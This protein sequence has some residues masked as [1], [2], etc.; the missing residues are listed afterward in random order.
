LLENSIR[1]VL[2]HAWQQARRPRKRMGSVACTEQGRGS[3][4]TCSQPTV[5]VSH[6]WLRVSFLE[7]E[8]QWGVNASQCHT[9]TNVA[10]RCSCGGMCCLP[11]HP[12]NRHIPNEGTNGVESQ[13]NYDRSSLRYNCGIASSGVVEWVHSP[14]WRR[15][16]HITQGSHQKWCNPRRPVMGPAVGQQS[17]D[18]IGE[19]YKRP[20]MEAKAPLSE[21]KENSFCVPTKERK[22]EC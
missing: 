20:E 13:P 10:Y 16:S 3:G 1:T 7:D 18:R 9:V 14:V 8:T 2:I 21:G 15:S 12:T 4:V 19:R 11:P 6:I 17:T 5:S 22:E